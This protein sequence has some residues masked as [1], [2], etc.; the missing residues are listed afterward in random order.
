MDSL[1]HSMLS[2]AVAAA[3]LAFAVGAVSRSCRQPALIHCLWLVVLL[4]LITPPVVPLAV[5]SVLPAYPRNLASGSELS[6]IQI[7]QPFGTAP[8]QH[9]GNRLGDFRVACKTPGPSLHDKPAAATDGVTDLVSDRSAEEPRPSELAN[10]RTLLP[11][12]ASR[13]AV[14]TSA[15]PTWAI[16]L[17]ALWAHLPWEASALAVVL[18]G[19]VAWW[20]LATVRIVRFHHVLKNSTAVPQGW[21]DQTDELAKQLGLSRGP[22][23]QLV[24]GHV[25]PMLWAIGRR[26]R[27]LFPI[28]LW[29]TLEPD[30]QTSLLLH[31]L[32]HLRRRDH[33]VRWLELL[34][35]GLYWW[36]PAVWWAR[37]A[38]REAEEQ[39]CDAWVVWAM[40]RAAKTYAAALLAA[41][42]FVSG[43]RAAAPAAASATGGNGHVSCL[44]RRLRMIMRANTP[45]RLSWIGRLAVVG[46]AALI[47]PLAPTWARDNQ[48]KPDQT[49]AVQNRVDDTKSDPAVNSPNENR[50]DRP[51]LA[52]SDKDETEDNQ[53]DKDRDAAKR[54][55]EQVRDLIEKLS[56]EFGPVGEELRKALDRAVGEVHRSL[57][58]ENPSADDLRQALEKSQDEMRRAL[59][60]G[61]PVDHQLREAW[62]RSRKELRDAWEKARDD[63]RQVMRDRVEVARQRQREQADQA[64]ERPERALPEAGEGPP[65]EAEARQNRQEVENAR[66]EIRELEQQLRR[67]TRR[68]EELDRRESRRTQRRPDARPRGEAEPTPQPRA[69]GAPGASP[70]P[71]SQPAPP[72]PA[73]RPG[74]RNARRPLV[75]P[76]APGSGRPPG[77]LPRPDYERRFRN[78]EDK[79]NQ[80]LKELQDMKSEQRPK[81]SAGPNAGVV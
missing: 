4:K 80:L 75:P 19:A 33:W 29:S 38:L 57:D 62:E 47:L 61:G 24:P 25:P 35:G 9:A 1:V 36:H 70:A 51:L 12:V 79:L 69:P 53:D 39:C 63:I 54:L 32:A 17:I 72:T 30:E 26:P 78:L 74:Q 65:D 58:K 60:E 27:L 64:R 44:K 18:A 68:L 21:Q 48:A 14:R 3:I 11:E 5:G 43:A 31:E 8:D 34:V 59:E 52:R 67:A 50:T 7:S 76:G 28:E 10:P 37:R 81:T 13:H 22:E 55:E 15:A 40:P 41:L 2:N 46:M 56:K 73:Q 71:R 42:E 16:T 20:S 77:P 6:A 23:V 49:G 45:N 66:R